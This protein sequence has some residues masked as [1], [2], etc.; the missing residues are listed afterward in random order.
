L[1]QKKNP[2]VGWSFQS[3]HNIPVAEHDSLSKHN[4]ATTENRFL[5]TGFST[6]VSDILPPLALLEIPFASVVPKTS[7]AP[8]FFFLCMYSETRIRSNLKNKESHRKAS[9]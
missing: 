7:A 8:A 3:K 5:R 9:A 2:W 6:Q 1:C 4:I